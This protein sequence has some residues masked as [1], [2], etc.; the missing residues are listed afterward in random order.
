MTDTRHD[1]DDHGPI[2][3]EEVAAIRFGSE[4]QG[5]RM[6]PLADWLAHPRAVPGLQERS[7]IA[8]S[9]ARNASR[10]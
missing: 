5:W 2:L 3:P 8:L 10:G 1:L 9:Q 6:L 4:G 7:A